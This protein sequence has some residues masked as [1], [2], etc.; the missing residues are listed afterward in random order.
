MSV[1]AEFAIQADEFLLGELIA[2]FPNLSVELERVIPAGGQ[3]M[4]YIWGY[5]D[6]LDEFVEVM[7]RDPN[8]REIT[9]LDQFE[10][11]ALYKIV[12][13]EPAEQL[14]TGIAEADATILEARS[15]DEW[16]F[17]IRFEDHAGL[18]AFNRYCTDHGI[19]FTLVRVTTLAEAA[20]VLSTYDLTEPQYEALRLAVERGY[21]AVPREVTFEELADELGVSVQ[22]FSE[23]VRRGANTVLR[24]A[25]LL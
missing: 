22:A 12:W 14:I 2:E 7:R 16:A 8:V 21:F 11:S 13:E 23:R 15:D 10:E 5:G 19:A 4:P 1:V 3:V 9:I 6:D 24:T 25:L 17:K 18:T 20:D